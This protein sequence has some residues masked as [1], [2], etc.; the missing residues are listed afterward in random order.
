MSA[1]CLD[2]NGD[3]KRVVWRFSVLLFCFKNLKCDL[4]FWSFLGRV[5]ACD[6]LYMH[7]VMSLDKNY[8]Q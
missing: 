6:H 2:R 7:Y 5:L 8:G 4:Q 1:M 3:L